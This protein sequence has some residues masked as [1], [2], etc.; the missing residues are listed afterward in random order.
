VSDETFVVGFGPVAPSGGAIFVSATRFTYRSHRHMPLV[1]WHGLALRR[2]WGRVEGAIG[3]FSGASLL[4]RTTYTVTAWRS[5]KDL[6]RWM[7][8]PY[9]LRLMK[10]YRGF[11]ESSSAVSWT[12]EAFEPKAAWREALS[13]LRGGSPGGEGLRASQQP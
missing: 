1:L 13:R 12:E 10:D 2:E 8:S 7:R 11:L 6:R 5:E 3:M 4:E 9:H